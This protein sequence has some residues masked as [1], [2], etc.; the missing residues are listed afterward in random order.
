MEIITYRAHQGT[1]A[2]YQADLLNAMHDEHARTLVLLKWKGTEDFA[3][4]CIDQ[5]NPPFSLLRD[6]R[7]WIAGHNEKLTKATDWAQIDAIRA[8][9]AG[10]QIYEKLLSQA[11]LYWHETF[12]SASNQT[13]VNVTVEAP[14]VRNEITV[15]PA[16]VVIPARKSETTIQRD[17]AGNIIKATQIEADLS[18]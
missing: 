16:D 5:D 13:V 17:K 1:D 9:R 15:Q 4:H 7:R 10:H 3:K 2:D 11:L 12:R 6:V 8:Q 14:E 18:V